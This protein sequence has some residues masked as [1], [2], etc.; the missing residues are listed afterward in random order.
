MSLKTEHNT[1]SC[2]VTLRGSGG[3]EGLLLLSYG[4]F[5]LIDV[6]SLCGS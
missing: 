5:C 4:F 1:Q 2:S 3:R 6:L